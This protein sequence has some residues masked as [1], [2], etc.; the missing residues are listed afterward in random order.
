MVRVI[1]SFFGL[2]QVIVLSVAESTS[3]WHVLRERTRED[4]LCCL[5][6]RFA[7]SKTVERTAEQT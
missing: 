2:Q 4:A 6:K 7:R 3:W 1:D 5:K